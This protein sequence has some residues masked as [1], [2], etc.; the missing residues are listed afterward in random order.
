M[1]GMCGLV[2]EFL[3]DHGIDTNNI[4]VDS[5]ASDVRVWNHHPHGLFSVSSAFDTIR[6]KRAHILKLPLISFGTVLRFVVY[7]EKRKPWFVHSGVMGN[8]MVGKLVKLIFLSMT[9]KTPSKEK[10]VPKLVILDKG[11]KL[12]ES[13]VNDMSASTIDEAAEEDFEGRPFRLGLGAKAVLE[14]KL[15]A[16]AD[17]IER[18]LRAKLNALKKRDAQIIED[19]AKPSDKDNDK[20]DGDEDDDGDDPDSR[21]KAFTKKRPTFLTPSMQANKKQK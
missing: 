13:W 4:H 16:S 21:S 17:P 8:A 7:D 14:S 12:A 2:D 6:S 3:K 19:S 20:A 5:S 11:L 1:A 15:G 10:I 18:R 9:T